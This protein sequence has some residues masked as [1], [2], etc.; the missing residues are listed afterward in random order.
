MFKAVGAL[1]VVAASLLY[2][3]LLAAERKK[4]VDFLEKTAMSIEKFKSLITLSK[5]PVGEAVSE[6]ELN[7]E[8][9]PQGNDREKMQLFLAS[10]DTETEE[11]I[12]N[13]ADIY[14]SEILLQKRPA[15]E[16]YEKEARLL[17]GS[18]AALGLLI[19][20]ILY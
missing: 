15:Q 10:L 7:P 9:A 2:G 6:S 13:V 3:F 11:G 18:F 19:S 5:L 16:K 1:L 14:L 20:I 17:K 4:R 8:N 12:I